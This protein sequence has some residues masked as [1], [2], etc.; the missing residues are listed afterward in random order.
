[1]SPESGNEKQREFALEESK[2]LIKQKFGNIKEVTVLSE[3]T[4]LVYRI[5]TETGS[6]IL[7]ILRPERM[8]HGDLDLEVMGRGN[9]PAFKKVLF[10]SKLSG[11][12]EIMVTEYVE[13]VAVKDLLYDKSQD[14]DHIYNQLSV[15]FKDVG[16][17]PTVA[18]GIVGREFKGSHPDWQSF[19]LSTVNSYQRRAPDLL[20]HISKK[21]ID[22][23]CKQV[24]VLD[25]EGPV[26]V[27]ADINMANFVIDES[28]TLRVLDVGSYLSGDSNLPMGLLL[29]HAWDTQ[30]GNKILEK[31]NTVSARLYLYAAIE[32]LAILTYTTK[33]NI[34]KIDTLKP[35]GNQRLAKDIFT[36]SIEK[37]RG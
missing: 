9:I 11:G 22:F 3:I 13:G 30:L 1:M 12:Q 28:G 29:G 2:N 26:L 25:L 5:D 4:H 37:L 15:F 16:K 31:N 21:E 24:E 7:K 27:P 33:F 14:F 17:I 36:E 32:M 35:F 10:D 19:L 34:E 23:L 18:Y 6:Y 20:E 8:S